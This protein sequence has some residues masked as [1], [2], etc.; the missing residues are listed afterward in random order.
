[1]QRSVRLDSRMRHRPLLMEPVDLYGAIKHP[2]DNRQSQDSKMPAQNPGQVGASAG[3][4]EANDHGCIL[5]KVLCSAYKRI[6]CSYPARQY[7]ATDL[8]LPVGNP[9][10][11]HDSKVVHVDAHNDELAVRHQ[12]APQALGCARADDESKEEPK[13]DGV[14]QVHLHVRRCR[15]STSA[16]MSTP[17]T[18]AYLLQYAHEQQNQRHVICVLRHIV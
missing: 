17:P 7:T 18:N 12:A 6:R 15:R 5:G 3:G 9:H 10:T 2:L 11:L 8:I 14:E 13:V 16:P 4:H 1:M